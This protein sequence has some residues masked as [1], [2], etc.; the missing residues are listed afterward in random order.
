MIVGIRWIF[1]FFVIGNAYTDQ[2]GSNIRRHRYAA[3][4]F[5]GGSDFQRQLANSSPFKDIGT[6]LTEDCVRA[7][8]GAHEI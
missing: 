8:T 4:K 5:E 3:H 6:Q 2:S 1:A 7:H